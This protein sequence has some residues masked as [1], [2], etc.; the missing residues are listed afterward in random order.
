MAF[1]MSSKVPGFNGGNH[2]STAPVSR[3]FRRNEEELEMGFNRQRYCESAHSGQMSHSRTKALK[4]TPVGIV[5][6]EAS[7]EITMHQ[8]SSLANVYPESESEEVGKPQVEIMAGPSRSR[9]KCLTRKQPTPGKLR[10][11]TDMLTQVFLC[12]GKIASQSP[13]ASEVSRPPDPWAANTS[14]SQPASEVN[15]LSQI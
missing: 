9:M 8:P 4:L 14:S 2:Q 1:L 10:T 7:A 5:E 3:L 11:S 12:D 15:L 6:E 13:T